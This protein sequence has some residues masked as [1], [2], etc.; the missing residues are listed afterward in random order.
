MPVPESTVDSIANTP[1]TIEQAKPPIVLSGLPYLIDPR[2]PE[3]TVR[4]STT[5][6]TAAPQSLTAHTGAFMLVEGPAEA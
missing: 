6:L 5:S 4:V 1:R 2:R 3:R